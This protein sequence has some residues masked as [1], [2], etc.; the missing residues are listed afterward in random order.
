MTDAFEQM[1][2]PIP[3]PKNVIP[4][5]AFITDIERHKEFTIL[6]ARVVVDAFVDVTPG[7]PRQIVW[8]GVEMSTGIEHWWVVRKKE[9]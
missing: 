9:S 4:A 5:P 1:L 2:L 7:L 3:K 6:G 8:R